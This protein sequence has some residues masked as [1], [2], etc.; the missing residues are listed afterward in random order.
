MSA[1]ARLH[2]KG[3]IVPTIVEDGYHLQ[4]YP[5]DHTPAHVHVWKNENE[6]RV[7]LDSLKVA[8]NEG[9]N[10]RELK[11]VVELVQKHQ[12]RLLSAWDTYHE[13]R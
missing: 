10:P 8:S 2:A 13:S 7:L 11:K 5:N 9:F 6:A 1:V 4:I 12:L 3:D